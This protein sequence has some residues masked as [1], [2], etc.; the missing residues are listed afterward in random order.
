MRAITHCVMHMEVNVII[1]ENGI[2]DGQKKEEEEKGDGE[3]YYKEYIAGELGFEFLLV[4]G[5]IQKIC[6]LHI[7]TYKLNIFI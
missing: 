1:Q 4:E 7:C 6:Y 3:C 2:H 5:D